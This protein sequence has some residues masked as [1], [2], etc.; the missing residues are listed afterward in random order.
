MNQ[1]EHPSKPL[2]R[3][4]TDTSSSPFHD[5]TREALRTR[6]QTH[7]ELVELIERLQEKG[8]AEGSREWEWAQNFCRR[9]MRT[10]QELHKNFTPAD[11]LDVLKLAAQLSD[12]SYSDFFIQYSYAL[13]QGTLSND[14]RR[15]Y[16]ETIRVITPIVMEAQPAVAVGFAPQILSAHRQFDIHPLVEEAFEAFAREHPRRVLAQPDRFNA[17][18]NRTSI[19]QLAE[20]ARAATTPRTTLE[21]AQERNLQGRAKLE[22]DFGITFTR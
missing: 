12:H 22:Q 7:P 10:M 5:H 14:E 16:S 11:E 15:Q 20:E 6:A 1:N 9:G 8:P 19:M 17:F 2:P 18:P 4:L 13:K 21:E 3:W